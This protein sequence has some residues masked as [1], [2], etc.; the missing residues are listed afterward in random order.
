MTSINKEEDELFASAEEYEVDEDAEI[1]TENKKEI[2]VENKSLTS[3]SRIPKTVS[4]PVEVK[5]ILKGDLENLMGAVIGFAPISLYDKDETKL[6]MEYNTT[7]MY[8]KFAKKYIESFSYPTDTDEYKPQYA[9][10]Y[11][12]GM[13]FSDVNTT[14]MIRSTGWELIKFI[15]KKLISGDFNLTKVSIPIKVMVPISILH[16]ISNSH[17]NVPLYLNLAALSNDPLQRMKLAIVACLSSWHRSNLFL[18]PLNPILGETYEMIWED[19]GR[20]YVEQTCHHPPTS[21]F[22]LYGPNN[23]YRYHG[24]ICYTSNAW[25]NSL[26]LTNTGKRAIEFNDSTIEFN[27]NVDQ[28][29]NSFWGVLRLECV[30]EMLFRDTKN[31]INTRFKLGKAGQLSDYFEGTINDKDGNALSSFKGSYLSHIA[32]D[33]QRYWDIRRN[34]DIEPY[35]VKKQLPSS[36]IYRDDSILLFERKLDEAQEAKDRLENLQ[37]NDRKLREKFNEEHGY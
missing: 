10:L 13:D 6:G 11:S 16:H 26:K 28:Y 12:G 15:G 37:R 30:G 4:P 17:F 2:I 31:G 24:Y 35:P 25:F 32:F 19:G 34:V 21:H 14:S 7:E 20:E 5:S 23:N 27:Y 29:N 18:K 22:I 3:N 9:N 1:E 33:N 36:S 8:K